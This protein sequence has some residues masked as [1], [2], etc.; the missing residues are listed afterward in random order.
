MMMT[1]CSCSLVRKALAL[2]VVLEF[3][4]YEELI[5]QCPFEKALASLMLEY[6]SPEPKISIPF[7]EATAV[8]VADQVS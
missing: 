1:L 3:H 4:A 8:F 6:Q 5:E 7:V 2:V